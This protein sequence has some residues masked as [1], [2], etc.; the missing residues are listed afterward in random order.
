MASRHYDFADIN[1]RLLAEVHGV[2]KHL[3]PNGK[4]EGREFVVGDIDGS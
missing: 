4:R 2:L 1:S 3:Y